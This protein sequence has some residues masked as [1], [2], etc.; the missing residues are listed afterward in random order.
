MS[1][2]V[3]AIDFDD[4][5]THNAQLCID[6]YN[7]QHDATI[8]LN[9]VYVEKKLGNP[10]HGWKHDPTQA[11]AWIREFLLSDAGLSNPPIPGT[12]A[13]LQRLHQKYDLVVVTGRDESWKEGTEAWLQRFAPGLFSQVH[14]SGE[15]PKFVTCKK[16]G[17]GI[18]ID[19]NLSPLRLCASDGMR[20]ILFGDYPWNRSD[21]L[22]EGIDRASNWSA[23]Q[24]LLLGETA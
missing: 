19:D 8:S 24:R 6:A 22:P 23:V 17:A 15:I 12:V 16:I 2:P 9:D 1:K 11:L 14:H 4:T 18:M 5:L 3:L 10:A 21:G 7:Q 20:G 13:A